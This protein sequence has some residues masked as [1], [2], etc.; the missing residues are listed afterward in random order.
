MAKRHGCRVV[1]IAG[2]LEKCQHVVSKL[3]FDVCLDY[4]SPDIEAELAAA[5]PAGV[6]VFFENVGGDMFDRV[7]GHMNHHGRIAICGL[8]AHYTKRS[9]VSVS[10]LNRI[11]DAA[12]RIRGFRFGEH[13]DLQPRATAELL[14]AYHEGRLTF[15]I[16]KAHGLEKA[17]EAL[18]GLQEG[19]SLGKTVVDLRT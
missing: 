16:T 3:G 5:L 18:L 6:D 19:R 8:I 4:R 14:A 1:G 11:L 7:L 15:D 9:P 13:L 17:P 2:G 12:L 10:N